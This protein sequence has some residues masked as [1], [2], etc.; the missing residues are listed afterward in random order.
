MKL[1]LKTCE[2]ICSKSL[3]CEEV[4]SECQLG[5]E[6]QSFPSFILKT[7]INKKYSELRIMLVKV[8]M[9]LGAVQRIQRT[10]TG[11]IPI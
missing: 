9:L 2:V 4:E 6:P 10:M 5:E 11:M 7:Q 1:R 3:I 8:I